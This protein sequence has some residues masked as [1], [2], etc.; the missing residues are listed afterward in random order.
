MSALQSFSGVVLNQNVNSSSTLVLTGAAPQYSQTFQLPGDYPRGDTGSLIPDLTGFQV[1]V[2]LSD[3]DAATLTW[4]LDRNDGTILA[5]M[6]TNLSSGVTTGTGLGVASGDAYTGPAWFNVYFP[7]TIPVPVNKLTNQYQIIISGAT[8]A[9]TVF[10]TTP[11]PLS[12]GQ[13]FIGAAPGATTAIPGSLQFR[14]LAAVADSGTD[15]LGNVYRSA[16]TQSVADNIAATSAGVTWLS[17]PSP[18]GFAV[19]SLY[20]DMRDDSGEAVVL[21]RLT[22]EP[23][24]PGVYFHVYYSNDAS[25][26]GVDPT[27]WANLLWTPVYATYQANRRDTYAFPEPFE[28]K[29]TKVEFTNLQA[30]SYNPGDFE[31]PT[32]YNKYPAW[33]LNYFLTLFGNQELDLLSSGVNITYDALDLAFSYYS[34]DIINEPDPP[35]LSQLLPTPPA[36]F[37]QQSGP[38]DVLDTTT[39]A[40]IQIGFQP[41]VS[42]P[43]LMGDNASNQ[44]FYASATATNNYA[45]EDP[46]GAVGNT[47]LVSNLSREALLVEKGFPI[48]FFFLPCRHTYRVAQ[49]TFERNVGYF[50]GVQELAFHREL[51]TG[52]G[53]Q[54]QYNEILGDSINAL[55]DDLDFPGAI[56]P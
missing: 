11:N 29:Y 53:D 33:I 26:P 47:S 16:L 10:Y 2:G 42:P 22:L 45:T 52:I 27:S 18:S 37:I 9:D 55:Y 14:V 20:F 7:N 34:A 32:T 1:R 56:F 38:S 51:Y 25:G 35:P 39:L 44:S 12:T 5:P 41:Y 8:G 28:A 54:G 3:A 46:Q 6:W 17:Q 19:E 50:A 23:L 21:D 31:I 48:M 49:A 43:A 40:K 15:F 30:R 36:A 13:A 4:E 24:T